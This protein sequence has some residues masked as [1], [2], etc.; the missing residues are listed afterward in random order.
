M[1]HTK[2]CKVGGLFRLQYERSDSWYRALIGHHL[3]YALYHLEVLAIQFGNTQRSK[4]E[5]DLMT[6][7]ITP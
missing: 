1:Y 4:S 6:C 7:I 2:N 5:T 3:V